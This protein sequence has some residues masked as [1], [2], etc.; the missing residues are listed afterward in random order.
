MVYQIYCKSFC[1]SNGDGIGDLRGVMSKLPV[2]KDLGIDC[3]WFTPIYVSPQVDGDVKFLMED[4]RQLLV[5]TRTCEKQKLLVIANK[6]NEPAT[7]QLPVELAQKKWKRLLCNRPNVAPSL[8]S[9]RDLNPWETEV[10]T[11]EE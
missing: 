1:D 7:V 8:E 11:L 5:Y 3:I 9:V 10:Y 2:L 6:S 4:S